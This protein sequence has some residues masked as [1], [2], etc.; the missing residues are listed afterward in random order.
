MKKQFVI[1]GIIILLIV[2]G[3]SGCSENKDNRFIGTWKRQ[4]P[5]TKLTFFSDGTLT[6]D[7][8]EGY[9]GNWEIKNG[10]I[11]LSFSNNQATKEYLYD[12]SFSNNDKTF[13][14][15]AIQQI[16]LGFDCSGV[17]TKQ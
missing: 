10:K 8:I 12:F 4:E 3:L 17:Y 11:I 5:S 14:L 2:I 15:T 7:F 6:Q 1:F 13:T 9:E 16:D